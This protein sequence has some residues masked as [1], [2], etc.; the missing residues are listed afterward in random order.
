[1]LQHLK[2]EDMILE[3]QFQGLHLKDYKETEYDSNV[4]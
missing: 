1:M 4:Y 2:L 3:V